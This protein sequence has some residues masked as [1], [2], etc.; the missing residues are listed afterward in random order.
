MSNEPVTPLIATVY[1]NGISIGSLPVAEHQQ[2]LT[3]AK[4]DYW[5][6]LRQ[7]V[8]IM[9]VTLSVLSRSIAWIPS[10][11]TLLFFL[12][13]MFTPA[14][15]VGLVMQDAV[16]GLTN[17]LTMTSPYR[18]GVIISYTCGA[19]LAC[20]GLI[21]FIVWTVGDARRFGY[22]DIFEER[23]SFRLRELLE[24]PAKGEISVIYWP[25]NLA[26][27]LPSDKS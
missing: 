9:W 14:Q 5:L 16:N 17:A 27:V 6:Y 22:R 19:L 2:L 25:V 10:M 13:V 12:F 3:E 23:V 24:A 18:L 11:L 20:S 7:M 21:T 26:E 8:N 1:L 4:R 15:N